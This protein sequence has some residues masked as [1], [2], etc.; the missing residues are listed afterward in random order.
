MWLNINFV[1]INT[2]VFFSI[3]VKMLKNEKRKLAEK[4]F[5]HRFVFGNCMF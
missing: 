5:G 2:A 3:F 1:G 4:D